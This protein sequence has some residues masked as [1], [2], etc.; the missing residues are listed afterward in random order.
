[1]RET[2]YRGRAIEPIPNKWFY[3]GY[4]KKR[5]EANKTLYR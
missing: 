5:E 3:G 2:K 4:V 1:M